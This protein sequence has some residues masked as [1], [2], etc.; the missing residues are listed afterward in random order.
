MSENAQSQL[1]FVVTS[2][3]CT[4][5]SPNY[6]NIP[7]IIAYAIALND[8][9]EVLKDIQNENFIVTLRNALLSRCRHAVY[10][11]AKSVLK[12]ELAGTGT[13]EQ[14]GS[15][16]LPADTSGAPQDTVDQ[17]ALLPLFPIYEP[18]I[19]QLETQYYHFYMQSPQIAAK[20]M[21][22]QCLELLD[23]LHR[24]P[25]SRRDKVRSQL[26]SKYGKVLEAEGEDITRV[27]E[28]L[29]HNYLKWR[30]KLKKSEG[31]FV[32]TVGR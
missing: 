18:D 2:G 3:L 25:A 4:A 13:K 31:V 26:A 9:A 19:A 21:Y 1:S 32:A 24:L 8:S 7:L 14:I 11:V 20:F 15:I 23:K 27:N 28:R 12:I 16:V 17:A 22:Q 29:W 10:M 5:M 30:C 6:N